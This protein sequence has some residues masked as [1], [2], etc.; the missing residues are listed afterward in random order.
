MPQRRDVT[1]VGAGAGITAGVA[2]IAYALGGLAHQSDRA[3]WWRAQALAPRPTVT[4]TSGA[5]TQPA[6]APSSSTGTP[7]ASPGFRGE[8]V[9]SRSTASAPAASARPVKPRPS[10]PRPSSPPSSTPTP[11]PSPSCA[12]AAVLTVRLPLTVLPCNAVIA[13]GS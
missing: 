10:S 3:D 13:G 6:A 7:G 1:A 4:V 9:S 12:A 5:S 2:L 8:S 11:K